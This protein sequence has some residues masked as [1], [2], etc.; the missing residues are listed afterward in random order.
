[1]GE[2]IE[3]I[4]R[5]LDN[6]FDS[7]LASMKPHVLKL[8]HKTERQK[9]ALWIKKLCDNTFS[10]ISGKYA[11]ATTPFPAYLVNMHLPTGGW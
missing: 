5:K 7:I 10:G 1:M 4:A 11:R 6:E 2:R 8:P 3:E 9:C